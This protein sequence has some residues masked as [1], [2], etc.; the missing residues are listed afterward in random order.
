MNRRIYHFELEGKRVLGFDTGLS[1]LA[2]AQAKMAQA[3]T[4]RGFI[5]I[6][7]GGVET[8]K[9][10]GVAELPGDGRTTMVN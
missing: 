10:S 5:V 2:F 4:D 1:A 9:A 7:E 3:I 6:P 8:W